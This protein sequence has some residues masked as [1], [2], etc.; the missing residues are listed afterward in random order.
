MNT[1][2]VVAP[3]GTTVL[4]EYRVVRGGENL[5]QFREETFDAF[6]Y[7]DELG[8][9]VIF[10]SRTFSPHHLPVSTDQVKALLTEVIHRR[11]ATNVQ[12]VMDARWVFETTDET[13]NQVYDKGAVIMHL[14]SD[15]VITVSGNHNSLRFS[16]VTLSIRLYKGREHREIDVPF[17]RF[18]AIELNLMAQRAHFD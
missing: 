13:P 17:Q 1:Q 18:M 4:P 3:A 12:L 14:D 16:N 10:R 6:S 7:T 2:T 11:D 15:S 8:Q 5:R 9:E